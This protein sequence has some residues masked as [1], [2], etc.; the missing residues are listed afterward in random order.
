MLKGKKILIGITGSIAA[1]KIISLVRLLTKQGAEV[2]VILTPTATQFVSPLVLSTLTKKK[3]Y[4]QLEEENCW[5]NH[6]ALG[7]WAD[8]ML[9]APLSA[10]TLSKIASGTCDSLLMA[11]YLSATC[12][13]VLAPAMDHDMWMHPSIKH[14]IK[15]IK[16][17]DRHYIIPV[18]YGELASGLVGD[19]RMAEVEDVLEYLIV[20][21]FRKDI[22]KNKSV[23]ITAGPTREHFDPVRFL[24]NNSSGKMG[25]AIA[26][27]AYLQGANV[28]IV[29]GPVSV[30]LTYKGIKVIPV[31]STQD[32]FQAVEKIFPIADISIFTAAASDYTPVDISL[33]KIKKKEV[34]L[35]IALKA[36]TDILKWAGQHKKNNQWLMG[37]ALETEQ[38]KENAL[39][40]LHGKHLDAVA[41]NCI[42]P[43]HS[44]FNVD[45]NTL[46]IFDKK[47]KETMLPM[48][49]KTTLASRIIEYIVEQINENS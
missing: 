26:E 35:P 10:N 48:Q 8:V 24:S 17:W 43:Q 19:G 46:T 18:A 47:E 30:K 11:V 3:V 5:A 45:T 37:F 2:Q 27:V 23:L 32:M 38:G 9:I 1:Y 4:I 40:K 36:T 25:Y 28:T 16:E 22:L 29:S 49:A 34:D 41:L 12:P 21:F 20:H 33:H 7:R 13:V 31:I 39:K 6:V 42:T 14:N 15:K 44:C